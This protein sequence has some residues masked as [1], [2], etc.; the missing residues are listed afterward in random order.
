MFLGNFFHTFSFDNYETVL[1]GFIAIENGKVSI[2]TPINI[3]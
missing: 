2:L 3:R 1:N